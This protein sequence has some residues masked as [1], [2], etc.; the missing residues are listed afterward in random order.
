MWPQRPADYAGRSFCC[1]A[2][3]R[4]ATGMMNHAQIRPYFFAILITLVA[5]FTFFLLQPFLTTLA[6]AGIFSVILT[7]LYG[8]LKKLLGLPPGGTAAVTLLVGALLIAAPLSFVISR[9]VVETQSL[10]AALS[11]PGSLATLQSSILGVGQTLNGLLPGSGNAVAQ[12][13]RDL[14][15]YSQ[16]AASWA[17][18]HAAGAFSGT[19]RFVLLLFVFGM[20]LYYLLTDGAALKRTVV[21]LSPL[22]PAETGLLL[23]R[24]SRTISSVVRGNMTIALIQGILV[25]TGFTIFGIPSGI[26]WGT[27]ASICALIP[28]VGTS[29]IVIPG[30]LYLVFTGATGAAIGL[31]L[32]SIVIVGLVDNFL[33]PRLIGRRAS[34]HPLLILLSV[35]GGLSMF[36]PEGVFLG[37]LVVSLLIGLL[38]IYSPSDK[39]RAE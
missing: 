4:Y 15:T 16:Q 27:V 30:I 11:E 17:L 22:T 9:L 5:V 3:T 12:F 32:W 18:G 19:L 6:L 20:T 10:Y 21:R 29:L 39:E 23:D 7:P 24:L 25:A 26:L 8:R 35:L 31:A 1:R 33:S 28:G 34:I 37:P 36:G 2:D 38:S 14:S 13:S